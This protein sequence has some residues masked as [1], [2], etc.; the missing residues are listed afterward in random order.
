MREVRL[1]QEL[2]GLERGGG[3]G[4]GGGRLLKY[5]VACDGGW[6]SVALRPQKP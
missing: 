1:R 6:L 4:G 2:L 5:C 3:K